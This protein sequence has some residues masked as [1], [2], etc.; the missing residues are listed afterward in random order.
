M[1]MPPELL[2]RDTPAPE[3][4]RQFTCSAD[5]LVHAVEAKIKDSH[6][7]S[8][9]F[10]VLEAK[11]QKEPDGSVTISG[12]PR[13]N[14][15]G[16]W[17]FCPEAVE[18]NVRLLAENSLAVTQTFTPNELVGKSWSDKLQQTFAVKLDPAKAIESSTKTATALSDQ[19]QIAAEKGFAHFVEIS[20]IQK[21]LSFSN[22]DVPALTWGYCTIQN[23]QGHSEI[24]LQARVRADFPGVAPQ[25]DW[26]LESGPKL[27]LLE[28]TRNEKQSTTLVE[29]GSADGQRTWQQNAPWIEYGWT[30]GQWRN[31]TMPAEARQGICAGCR[32]NT[33]FQILSGQVQEAQELANRLCLQAYKSGFTL[34]RAVDLLAPDI[35][36]LQRDANFVELTPSVEKTRIQAE[37]LSG[38]EKPPAWSREESATLL[39]ENAVE[40][41]LRSSG[42]TGLYLLE[43]SG[44]AVCTS[45]RD[46]YQAAGSPE[47]W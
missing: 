47:R 2:R 4:P 38:A 21:A 28:R 22:T 14:I 29:I 26:P 11:V 25:T 43:L 13:S 33:A 24:A 23:P 37:K 27:R 31:S 16:P 8:F 34:D 41:K 44:R 46:R 3:A 17:R 39:F 30:I 12:I 45:D 18:I 10:F 1:W 20:H 6:S 35:K 40:K 5:E 7:N 15:F 19:L 36:P 32:E 9:S 42:Q